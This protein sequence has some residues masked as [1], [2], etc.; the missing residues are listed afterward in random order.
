MRTSGGGGYGSP[1]TA[2]RRRPR[3]MRPPGRGRR[4]P[5]TPRPPA[6]MPP[7]SRRWRCRPSW[8][9]P[10][11][12]GGGLPGCPL[13]DPF[14]CPYHHPFALDFWDATGSRR[15]RRATARSSASAGRPQ[16]LDSISASPGTLGACRRKLTG[17]F[18]HL[19][20]PLPHADDVPRDR[21]PSRRRDPAADVHRGPP[22][23]P[24]RPARRLRRP[25]IEPRRLVFDT[26]T[27][28]AD[29]A[30]HAYQYGIERL[31]TAPE[32]VTSAAEG[33]ALLAA[34]EHLRG[35]VRPGAEGRDRGR[36]R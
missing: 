20:L 35:A 18:I 3:P 2:R 16:R 27:A 14:R 10:A 9:R 7:A 36:S 29:A 4:R 17:C 19:R 1:A 32:R 8:A 13:D 15:G 33:K 28:I 12:H 6:P 26:V 11:A 22:H 25:D 21:A 31:L 34:D 5:T 23:P 30:A 24:W